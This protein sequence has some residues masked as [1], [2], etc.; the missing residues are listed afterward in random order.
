ML[1]KNTSYIMELTSG[2][3]SGSESAAK[4]QNLYKKCL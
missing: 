2:F 3:I 4:K 1:K